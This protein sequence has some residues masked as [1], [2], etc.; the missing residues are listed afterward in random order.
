MPDSEPPVLAAVAT[1]FPEH[2][3]GRQETVDGL[4][5]L[6]P[7]EDPAFLAGIVERSG[8]ELRHTVEP[9]EAIL[10]PTDFTTR[11]ALYREAAPR[12]AAAAARRALDQAALA[13]DRVDAVVDV[14]CTG[15]MI[16]ALDVHLASD[17]GLRSDVLRLPVSES[18]CAAGA[19]GLGVAADLARRGMRVLVVAVELCSLT[20]VK[21][22]RTR[23]NL[24][25]CVLFGDGAAAAVVTPGP[26]PVR[27]LASGHHLFPGTRHAMGFDV[28]S[29]GLRIVLDREL[30]GILRQGLKQVV[31][32]FLAR[33]GRR[34]EDVALHLV[35]PGGRRILD[36]YADMFGLSNGA[37]DPSREALRRFGNLSSASILAV[38]ELALTNGHR[39]EAG[40]EALLVAFGPG[41]TVEMGLLAFA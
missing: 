14:S 18:G 27:I 11:N 32:G 1:A 19:L 8:V 40:G 26:G 39:P 34:I 28:G 16:P 9:P 41:L 12:L 2:R 36:S 31:E 6:F 3:V 4:R 25:S 15:L 21:E 37:L 7:D 10:Q 24:V 30:P 35:H 5:R 33:H 29:H 23:T 38:T 22:D 17:L 20:L 13:P